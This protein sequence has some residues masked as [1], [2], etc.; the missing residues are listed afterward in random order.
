MRVNTIV[1]GMPSYICILVCVHLLCCVCVYVCSVCSL[2]SLRLSNL[3]HN[4]LA[5]NKVA[6]AYAGN[7][8][9]LH[10]MDFAI[11]SHKLL[12]LLAAFDYF[13]NRQ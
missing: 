4:Q 5:I 7:F 3:K 12:L 10:F 8:C 13:S 1:V 9:L 2:A 11:K 6:F